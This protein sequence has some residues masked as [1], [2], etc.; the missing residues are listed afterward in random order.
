MVEQRSTCRRQPSS[1][2]AV[3]HVGTLFGMTQILESLCFS[4]NL[5]KSVKSVKML[6][7]THANVGKKS[8]TTV[9]KCGGVSCNNKNAIS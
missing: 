4:R 7:L 5:L 3:L 1:P 2:F 8:A 9:V 6:F